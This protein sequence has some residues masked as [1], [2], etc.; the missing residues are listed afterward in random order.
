MSEKILIE[1]GQILK[2]GYYTPGHYHN[3][4]DRVTVHVNPEDFEKWREFLKAVNEEDNKLYNLLKTAF[5]FCSM[6]IPFLI[7]NSLFV[8]MVMAIG[9]HFVDFIRVSIYA[10]EDVV[11]E[12]VPHFYHQNATQFNEM[13]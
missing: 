5:A 11:K 12:V 7:I 2:K 13:F 4:G 3:V 6:A 1:E 9:D 10:M 8:S